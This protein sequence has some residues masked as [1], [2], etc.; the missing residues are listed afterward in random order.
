MK[1]LYDS[2]DPLLWDDAIPQEK[3]DAWIALIAEAVQAEEVIF[4]RRSRPENAVGGP[5]EA[6]FADGAKPAFGA[7]IYLVWEHTCP[8]PNSCKV[9]SCHKDGGHFSAHFVLGKARVT[10]LS[11]MTTP[12]SEMS[13]GVLVTRQSLRVAR[14]LN[15]M[16]ED[17]KPKSCV[18]ML[19]SECTIATVESPSKNLKPFFLNRKT[20]ILENLDSIRK[21]CPVEP[22]QWIPTE[23]NISD[24]L[25]R[26]TATPEDIG[27][28][29]LWQNGPEFLCLPR[30]CWPTS[31]EFVRD[32]K[33]PKEEMSSPQDYSYYFR[34]ALI[35]V[36]KAG[37]DEPKLFKV[38]NDILAKSNDMEHVKRVLARVIKGWGN[39]S[40]EIRAN[41]VKENLT[42]DDLVKAER[43]ILLASMKETLEAVEK[44][45]LDSLLPYKS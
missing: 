42:R 21:I 26:G 41:R 17:L 28:N 18:I 29:S 12:R 14:A 44:G 22:L 31:R 10:P 16:E 2:K 35:A 19:D 11:G 30:D 38:V 4:P 36:Q 33:I 43:L 27:P 8:E 6:G 40:T 45:K 7:C 15:C 5:T 32:A 20:E 34:T 3:K 24:I 23:H 9:E 13:G 1:D 25:T 37:K 39:E